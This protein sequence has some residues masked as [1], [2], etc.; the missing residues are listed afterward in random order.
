MS[1]KNKVSLADYAAKHNP[2]KTRRNKRMTESYLYRLIREDIA[3]TNTR[4][5]W[6][7]YILE[8]EKDRIWI[9]LK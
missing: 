8:G 9:I 2:I 7:K 6:F 4:A 5:L 1:N 3:G